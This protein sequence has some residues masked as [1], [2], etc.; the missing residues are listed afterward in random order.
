MIQ[1]SLCICPV[2]SGFS[3][4]ASHSSG[5]QWI[6]WSDEDCT[7]WSGPWLF[8]SATPWQTCLYLDHKMHML[9]QDLSYCLTHFHGVD[10]STE[11]LWNH[12]S[13][14]RIQSNYRTY[15]YKR[16]VKQFCCLWITVGVLFVYIFIKAHVVGT[17]LNCMDLLMQCKW[18]STT[19][20]YTENLKKKKQTN[21]KHRLSVII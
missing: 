13:I 5:K 15:P 21:K 18:V 2:W 7:G 4:S 12:F 1:I 17:H 10:S 8:T 11:T 3:L 20:F 19:C 6:L 14:Y 16:T 9:G